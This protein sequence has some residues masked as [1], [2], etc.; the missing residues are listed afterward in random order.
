VPCVSLLLRRS[1]HSSR[2]VF[3]SLSLYFG[4][5]L[6]VLPLFLFFVSRCPV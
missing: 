3:F 4:A 5:L 1:L 6:S 2:H